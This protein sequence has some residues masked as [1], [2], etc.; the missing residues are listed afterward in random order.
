[1]RR[2]LALIA[3]LLAALAVLVWWLSERTENEPV[4]SPG[5]VTPGIPRSS[6]TPDDRLGARAAETTTTGVD[7]RTAP[8]RPG[9][10]ATSVDPVDAG[11]ARADGSDDAQARA[12][13]EAWLTRNAA[14]AEK[15]VDAFCDLSKRLAKTPGLEPPTRER[16]ASAFLAGRA[17]WEDGHT[18]LLHLPASLTDR[19]KNPPAAWQ[20][21]GPTDY[22]GLDFTWMRELLAFDH[23]GLMTAG[24]LR[25]G[26]D[27]PAFEQIIPDFVTMLHWAKLRL[28][29]GLNEHDLA[30]ASLEV[31]HLATICASTSTLVGEMVRLSMLTLE[32]EFFEAQGLPPLDGAITPQTKQHARSAGFAARNFLMS[33]VAIAVKKKALACSQ[34]RCAAI[35][36]AASLLSGLRGAMP[37]IREDLDW[38]KEQQPCEPALLERIATS[39]PLSSV[40]PFDSMEGEFEQQLRE[41]VDGGSL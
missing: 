30:Q 11:L 27:L 4:P 9:D 14:L 23:W 32:R 6:S 31:R 20:R 10:A 16:D 21:F 22:A 15:H 25:D 17:D 19:M 28:A 13:V 37:R 34:T 33:G 36:E 29:K 24:P 1:M 12:A 41:M 5:A 35:N 18:G 3:G 7:D 2:R 39:P 38:L 8:L 26:R 40:P